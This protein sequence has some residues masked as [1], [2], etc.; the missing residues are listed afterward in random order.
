MNSPISM[1]PAKR[2]VRRK[3]RQSP[4]APV[5]LM[6][7]AVEDVSVSAEDLDCTLVFNTTEDAP[8]ASV[9]GADPAK[10]VVRYGG[11]RY[12]G[13]ELVNAAYDRLTLHTS[14]AGAEAGEDQVSYSADPSD[15]EDGLGRELGAIGAFPF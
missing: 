5:A 7:V 4:A 2:R 1:I 12:E 11:N 9:S 6:L 8:L 10:W 14:L 13:Y 3:R 15:I